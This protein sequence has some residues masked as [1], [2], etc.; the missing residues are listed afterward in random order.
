VFCTYG[1]WRSYTRR[2]SIYCVA[3]TSVVTSPNTSPSNRSVSTCHRD[4]I[5]ITIYV[6][7]LQIAESHYQRCFWPKGGKQGCLEKM[8]F[9]CLLSAASIWFEIWGVVD[10]G[11][12]K[13]VDFSGNFTQKFNFSRQLSEKFQFFQAISQKI[14]IFKAKIG[15]LQLLL[16][17]LFYFSSKVTTFE[18]TSCTL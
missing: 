15:H 12:N 10:P 5:V 6:A 4:D 16:G 8:V 1:H 14:S 2:R 11:K 9:K 13:I 17:K 3:T 18:H 7:P